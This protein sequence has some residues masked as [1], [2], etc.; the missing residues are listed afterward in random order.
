[1][2]YSFS[3]RASSKSEA[4]VAIDAELAKVFAS[5]PIHEL[6]RATAQAVAESYLLMLRDE[7]GMDVAVSMNGSV[8]VPEPGA[9]TVSVSVTANLVTR[10]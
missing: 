8:Y 7:P 1:M 2:S 5:Q 3:V 9:Q 6:D 4:V 10:A